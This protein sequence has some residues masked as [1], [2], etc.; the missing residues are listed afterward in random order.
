MNDSQDDFIDYRGDE[1]DDIEEV[2]DGLDPDRIFSMGEHSGAK[3]FKIEAIALLE[4]RIEAY[5]FENHKD[6]L[7]EALDIIKNITT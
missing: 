7:L 1:D 5:R 6:G 2:L 3:E 4:H